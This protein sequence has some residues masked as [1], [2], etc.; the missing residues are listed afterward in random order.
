VSHSSP[1]RPIAF[2]GSG[3]QPVVIAPSW[4]AIRMRSMPCRCMGANRFGCHAIDASS[5]AGRSANRFGL[6]PGRRAKRSLFLRSFAHSGLCGAGNASL[7]GSAPT[8]LVH[9]RRAVRDACV[10]HRVHLRRRA[11]TTACLKKTAC[12]MRFFSYALR[13]AR[14][15][16][17]NEGMQGRG[18]GCER[19]TGAGPGGQKKPCRGVDS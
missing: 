1:L 8:V 9:L 18:A 10:V 2:A 14:A 19:A 15:T 16:P 13:V 12:F 5:S 7:R 6:L 3:A 17:C 11:C 4:H